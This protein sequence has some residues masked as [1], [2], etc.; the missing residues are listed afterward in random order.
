MK[1]KDLN[2]FSKKNELNMIVTEKGKLTLFTL[3]I[4]ILIE[5]LLKNLMGTVSV[6]IMSRISDDAVASI[7][8]ASQVLTMFVQFYTVIG[9]G[10]TVV[11]NQNLGAKRRKRASETAEAA[12]YLS[13]F[14]GS[15]IGILITIFAE[16]VI[17][18]MQLEERLIPDA[19]I[20]LQIT[21]G[22]SAFQAVMSSAMAISRAYGNTVYP[23][24]VSLIMNAFNAVGSYFVVFC[25]SNL[26]LSKVAGIAIVRIISEMIAC[27]L[28]LVLLKRAFPQICLKNIRSFK[29]QI[30]KDILQ[31]GIP[32]GIMTISYSTSQTVSTAILTALGTV[33]VSAKIYVTNIVLYSY[34]V[35]SSLGQANALMVG[36]LVGQQEY[37]KAYRMTMRNLFVTLFINAVF[38]S[39]LAM[40]RLTL[41]GF[42]TE[43]A[44]ILG[45]GAGVMI[46]DIFVELGRGAN[47]TFENALTASGD[48]RFPMII[49][50][51]STWGISIIFS[52]VL[53][54]KLGL[55]LRGCWIAFALDEILRGFIQ[56]ERWKSGIWKRKSLIKSSN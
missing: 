51:C 38:A 25:S 5:M 43:D 34:L 17:R 24:I 45:L 12:I 29:L 15:L 44:K 42:F 3:F 32:N 14:I 8:V 47:N 56:M 27:L 39:S 46:I 36:R 49:S 6:F 10:A 9:I 11:I 18:I 33:A 7:G 21:V 1:L 35:S 2:I 40:M 52:Y 13:F 19:V 28:M 22:L 30:V 41:L 16:P 23:V 31:I 37:E 53:G 50:I 4:P 48:T 54:V 20:Y 55:G 26:P